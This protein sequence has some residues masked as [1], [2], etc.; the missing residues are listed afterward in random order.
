MVRDAGYDAKMI[1]LGPV[2]PVVIVAAIALIVAIFAYL[3]AEKRRKELAAF[4]FGMGLDFTA[5]PSDVHFKYESFTPFG[6]GH[7][8]R[9]KNL[10]HGRRNQL[11]WE[12]F[13]YRYTTGSGKNQQTHHY[14][15]VAAQVS[16]A[17]PVMRIRPEGFF[18]KIAAVVGFDDIDFES[19]AFSRKYHVKCGDR[20]EAYDL[21]HPQMIE[22]LMAIR[23]YDWQFSGPWI[24]I[25][26][27]GRFSVVEMAAAM[28][29]IE[30][31]VERV[32][33]YVREDIGLG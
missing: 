21:I 13:D 10:I 16:L 18:D 33:E 20:K 24:L 32:P 26:K 28:E 7:S 9:S 25:H 22:Y 23:P 27:S 8:R 14:G 29:A 11:G 1:D 5:S 12:L 15:I 30:G 4:A 3:A 17:F 19:D 6:S 31:F 2:L